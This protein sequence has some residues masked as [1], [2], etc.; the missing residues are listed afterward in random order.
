MK[1]SIGLIT[2]QISGIVLGVFSVFYIAGSLPPEIY[3]LVGIYSVISSFISV[4][5]N[6]GFETHAIRNVLLWKEEKN[7]EAIKLIV[8]QSLVYRG[9]LALLLQLPMLVYAWYISHSSFNGQYFTLFILMVFTSIFRAL[10]DSAALLL[11][12]FNMYFAAALTSYSINVFGRLVALL[13]FFK[14]GFLVYINFIMLLPLLVT[15]PIFFL[16][17]KWISFEGVF[18][19][20]KLK[21]AIQ[22]SKTFALSAYVSYLFKYFD[23]LLVSIF[24]SLEILGSFTVAKS[25]LQIGIT[26]IE[27]LFDPL[28]QGLVKFKNESTEIMIRLRRVFKLKNLILLASI[29]VFPVFIIFLNDLLEFLNLNSY[30]HLFYFTVFIYLSQILHIALKVKT[31]FI[32]LFFPQSYYLKI[33]FLTGFLS[34]LFFILISASN[35]SFLFLHIVLQN[36]FLLVYSNHLFSNFHNRHIIST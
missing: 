8:T 25:L 13:L 29:I 6:T 22:S 20:N 16:L 2:L 11:K 7:H 33:T 24:L 36:I 10:N 5:S 30:R 34:L 15:V 31:N 19:K 14:F 26:F 32:C 3:A 17:R 28:I 23:H 1:Q 27:N 18:M 4:F 21:E 12:S 9:S 35:S